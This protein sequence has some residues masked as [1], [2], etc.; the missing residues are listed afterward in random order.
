MAQSGR[1][2]RKPVLVPVPTPEPTPTP[3][4]A[5]KPKTVLTFIV[6]IDQYAGFAHISTAIYDGVLRSCAERL[7]DPASVKVEVAQGEMGR[8]E[9][10]N[11]AKG[12]KEAYVVW[13][14]ISA[15]SMSGDNN[16]IWLEYA[17]FA[18]TTAKLVTSGKTYRDDQNKGVLR[19]RTSNVYGDYALNQAARQ[20]AERILAS[21][22]IQVPKGRFP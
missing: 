13:L 22:K 8:G 20:A 3:K 7:D 2:V 11:R 15:D 21:F 4:P 18:P 12:E 9:A 16:T 19:P 10:I 17:V 5:E 1:H 6:G 14:E